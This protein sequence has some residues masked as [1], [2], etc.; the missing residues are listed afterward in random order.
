MPN[1]LV[2]VF[3]LSIF[4]NVYETDDKSRKEKWKA[5]PKN[6]NEKKKRKER[7]NNMSLLF[8]F[9]GIFL[10]KSL[11]NSCVEYESSICFFLRSANN[12]SICD[13]HSKH[14]KN[15]KS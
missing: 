2:Y 13:S 9:C 11:H 5:S 15:G 4:G 10:F 6:T 3:T 14:V 8:I 7:I 12:E 1:N